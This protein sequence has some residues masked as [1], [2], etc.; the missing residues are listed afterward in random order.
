[1]VVRW[2]LHVLCSSQGLVWCCDTLLY[3]LKSTKAPDRTLVMRQY[4]FLPSLLLPAVLFYMPTSGVT[5][6]DRQ[7]T[8]LVQNGDED[9]TVRISSLGIEQSI[10]SIKAEAPFVRLLNN[11][12]SSDVMI[13]FDES[14]LS[15]ECSDHTGSNRPRGAFR[16]K[17]PLRPGEAARICFLN[18]GTYNYTVHGVPSAPQ[19]LRSSIVVE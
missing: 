6:M 16:S 2:R 18:P 10:V 8:V 3:G 12:N 4:L 5:E 17:T 13:T 19:G 7:S 9:R 1:M 15:S 11:S 14:A